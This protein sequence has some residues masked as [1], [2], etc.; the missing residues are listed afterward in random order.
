MNNRIQYI[1]RLKGLAILL[2]VIG[3]L[4]AFCTG[5]EYNPI[6]EIICS[7]HMPL[8]M[9]LS[10]IV[11][12]HTPLKDI[13][14][15]GKKAAR[16][17]L[18]MICLGLLFTFTGGKD[19]SSFIA[20]R[21]KNGYWYLYVLTIFYVVMY[22]YSKLPSVKH[23]WVLD[24][25]YLVVWQIAF[26]VADRLLGEKMSDMSDIS[27]CKG[28]WVYFFLGY[29]TRRHKWVEWLSEHNWAF[30]LALVSYVPLLYSYETGLVVRFGQVL[31]LT[32]IIIL[33]FLF[34][35]RE[36]ETSRVEQSLS[37]IGRSTLDIY[38]LHYFV[39]RIIDL[40][41]ASSY[42]H[43]SSNYL[44]E[45]I[46]LVAMALVVSG[47]CITVGKVLRQSDI[48]RRVVFGEFQHLRG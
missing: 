29:M 21:Y 38:V 32:A 42:L 34:R 26:M 7:F 46:M 44:L 24:I 4:M 36:H 18:P 43:Q 6:Y 9:F 19:L 23:R 33:V 39:L 12:A 25:A 14:Y 47:V 31:P 13:N 20:D 2:V 37:T 16:F 5:G 28:Y 17:M 35:L 40:T 22:V 1:D 41:D 8:F 11:I 27:M 30:T 3:H 48:I 15:L 10:G 45:F